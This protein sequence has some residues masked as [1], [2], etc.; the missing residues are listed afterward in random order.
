M[1]EML[2]TALR[3]ILLCLSFFGLCA[4][5]R[6]SLKLNRFIVPAFAACTIICV[7][8]FAGMLH[9]LKYGFYLLYFGGFAGLI[10]TYIV[11]RVRPDWLLIGLFAVFAGY[12]AWRMGP[13]HLNEWDDLSH[14]GLVARHLLRADA[15]PDA[16]TTTVTFQSYPLGSA[17][18]I[19]YVGRTVCNTEGLYLFAQ[20]LLCGLLF[21]PVLA[22]IRG[23]RRY[24]YP[25]A[26]LLF[27]LL[28]RFNHAM[29]TLFVDWQLSFLG[30][31]AA[32][33]VLYY[34]DDLRK[35]VLAGMP[36]IIA[37]V[38]LK[39]SGLFFSA[40]TAA[41]LAWVAHRNGRSRGR[42]AGVLLASILAAAAAYLLWT[43]HV[44]LDFVDGMS[45]KHAVSI[46]QY[47]S[48][49][50][51]KGLITVLR[52]VKRML[53]AL[54]HPYFFQVFSALFMVAAFALN[55]LACRFRPELQSLRR[56]TA[57]GLW[58]CVAAYAVW[59]FMVFLMYVFSMSTAE[60]LRLASYWRYST[61]GL[62]YMMGCAAILLFDLLSRPELRP[63][64]WVKFACIGTAVV[65]AAVA[66]I[67]AV[68]EFDMVE[69]RAY[70]PAFVQRETEYNP[71]RAG[72]LKAKEAYDLPEDGSYLI[73]AGGDIIGAAANAYYRA[74][75]Y[76]LNSLNIDIIARIIDDKETNAEYTIKSDEVSGTFDSPIDFL[77]S[78]LDN[79]DAFL[80][81]FEDERFETDVADFLSA[82][83]G[84]TPVLFIY[85]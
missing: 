48:N 66:P 69:L 85:R 83:T 24:L 29:D 36:C 77:E 16:S 33:S 68:S 79:Y 54:I 43:V 74:V 76:D 23:N 15:F 5:V 8:M 11:R 32:A 72:T 7:L 37:V 42:A 6:N 34:K 13:T 82:W 10:Y 73:Y 51:S 26:G 30:I 9:V 65:C 41:L 14:W 25:A 55:R 57:H 27:V 31:G 59:H 35:A 81:L 62:L 60:A 20:N 49:L 78:H 50:N 71:L 19:Y 2:L 53:L 52:I 4:T 84:D 17:C 80:I 21:T 47:A 64:R 61:T 63:A 12:L 44:R 46:S 22:H 75:K 38:F 58:A 39:N 18:F 70:Y 28:F 67:L 56:P 45:T 3:A 40:A 1:N